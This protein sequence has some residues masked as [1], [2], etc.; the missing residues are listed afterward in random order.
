MNEKRTG[1]STL[2][3]SARQRQCLPTAG[4]PLFRPGTTPVDRQ[5]ERATGFEADL[6]AQLPFLCRYAGSLTHDWDRAR[7][8]V[9]D[10]C[11]KAL[12][13]RELFDPATNLR[14][15]LVTIMR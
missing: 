6:V 12:R 14:A 4:A 13:R 8:L 7:D 11:E 15:W 1:H 9:Q 3:S 10:T 5:L 2:M